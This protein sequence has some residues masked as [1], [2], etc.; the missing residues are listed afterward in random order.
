LYTP[1]ALKPLQ[2]NYRISHERATRELDYC[3]RPLQETLLDTW[4]WFE[5]GRSPSLLAGDS[6]IEAP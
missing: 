1:A 2:G 5:T 6:K 4:N 3:P